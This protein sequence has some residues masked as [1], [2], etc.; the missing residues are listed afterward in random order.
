MYYSGSGGEK[1]ICELCRCSPDL[2]SKRFHKRAH[3]NRWIIENENMNMAFANG[4]IP[5]HVI[6]LETFIAENQLDDDQIDID[7]T[8]LATQFHMI[9]GHIF[10]NRFRSILSSSMFYHMVF[11]NIHELQY[12][13]SLRI[14]KNTLARMRSIEDVRINMIGYFGLD[15]GLAEFKKNRDKFEHLVHRGG[16]Y[17]LILDTLQHDT[18][19][20]YEQNIA[21]RLGFNCIL[22][23][24]VEY[25]SSDI[26]KD[27]LN[28]IV[29]PRY[30]PLADKNTLS[31]NQ[32][33]QHNAAAVLTNDNKRLLALGDIIDAS[34]MEEV[35]GISLNHHEFN[36]SMQSWHEENLQ[37]IKRLKDDTGV[38][39]I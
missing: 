20:Q 32:I 6:D 29:V 13:R 28:K 36:S 27:Y 19:D 30:Q 23:A 17:T 22:D 38:S 3:N 1:L 35:F 15:R 12:A 25:L 2:I 37:L 24:D 9:R 8:Q 10:I 4:S 21:N 31:R 5:D 34:K 33:N 14:V 7:P 11:G 26:V 18:V 16:M 39:L